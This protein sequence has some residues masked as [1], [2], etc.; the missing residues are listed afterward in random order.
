MIMLNRILTFTVAVF[1]VFILTFFV[2]SSE[3]LA[4]DCS[5]ATVVKVG[6]GPVGGTGSSNV[7]VQLMNNTSVSLGTPSW[8]PNTPRLFYL[9]ES[10]GKE[11]LAVLLTAFATGKKVYVRIL[12]T[13][14]E[15]SLISNVYIQ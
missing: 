4:V 14:A 1:T 2:A 10:I 9:H 8:A 11:G 12:G 15:Y 13:G 5:L 3:A 7:V 6:P